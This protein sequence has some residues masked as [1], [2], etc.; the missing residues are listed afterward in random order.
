MLEGITTLAKLEDVLDTWGPGQ[1]MF[2]TQEPR[3][4]IAVRIGDGFISRPGLD[5]DNKTCHWGKALKLPIPPLPL[6]LQ[7]EIVVGML[8]KENKAC[9]SDEA[10][11]RGNVVMCSIGTHDPYIETAANEYAIQAG[12]EGVN[13]TFTRVREK[14]A[15]KTVKEKHFR[16]LSQLPDL[17]LLQILDKNWA[18]RVSFCTLAA[19]R[20]PMRHMIGDLFPVFVEKSLESQDR[21]MWDKLKRDLVER[22]NGSKSNS[23]SLRPW[24]KSLDESVLSFVLKISKEIIRRLVD[25]GISPCGQFFQVAWPDDNATFEGVRVPINETTT[26]W[27]AILEDSKDSATFAYI[28]KACLVSPEALCRGPKPSLADRVS[29]LETAVL[30]HTREPPEQWTLCH[31]KKYYFERTGNLR[32]WVRVE[33][34]ANIATKPATLVRLHKLEHF[35]SDVGFRLMENRRSTEMRIRE[36]GLSDRKAEPVRILSRKMF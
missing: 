29:F 26:K 19:Q 13:A 1:I 12:Y 10:V 6:D 16:E 3:S 20:V 24:L 17:D 28:T 21:E 14:R 33:K 22:F 25:T 35:P 11:C 23:K 18:V 9:T 8:L 34:D 15:G 36:T 7:R 30:C 2:Q 27:M 4:P 5:T 32:Y 31:E